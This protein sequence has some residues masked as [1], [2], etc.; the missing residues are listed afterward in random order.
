MYRRWRIGEPALLQRC[1]PLTPCEGQHSMPR[2]GIRWNW[3]ESVFVDFFY[4]DSYYSGEA[5]PLHHQ[6]VFA[7]HIRILDVCPPVL[8]SAPRALCPLPHTETVSLHSDVAATYLLSRATR[9]RTLF[10]TSALH[11]DAFFDLS[12]ACVHISVFAYASRCRSRCWCM[13]ASLLVSVEASARAC[14]GL[15][16][17]AAPR[18]PGLLLV[19]ALQVRVLLR[20]TTALRPPPSDPSCCF[21]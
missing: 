8:Q 4:I 21:L 14:A 10:S 11:H 5:A 3:H 2:S 19:Q 18:A 13:S 9:P 17:D 12:G 6:Q 15:P 16:A 7:N 20:S 1:L